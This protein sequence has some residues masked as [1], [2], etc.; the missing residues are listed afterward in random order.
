MAAI[1][2]PAMPV[3]SH[4]PARE[5]RLRSTSHCSTAAPVP[6]TDTYTTTIMPLERPSTD[7]RGPP[8]ENPAAVARTH[9]SN[10]RQFAIPCYPWPTVTFRAIQG[11]R[12]VCQPG[13]V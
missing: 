2:A 8:T 13:P 1:A 12:M 4:Q 7:S 10:K 11:H 5:R 9:Q 3:A 6:P